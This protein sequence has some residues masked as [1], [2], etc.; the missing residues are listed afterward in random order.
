[1]NR[2]TILI[3]TFILMVAVLANASHL[4][5]ET[6]EVRLRSGRQITAKIHDRTDTDHLWLRYGTESVAV[7]RPVDWRTIEAAFH[8]GQPISVRQLKELASR[9]AAEV[10]KEPAVNSK[11]IIRVAPA[12]EGSQRETMAQRARQALGFAARVRSV[13]FEAVLSNWDGDVETD[14]L[15]LRLYPIDDRGHVIQVSGTLHV[16][17]I[18]RRQRDF[19]DARQQRGATV[20]QIGR[21]TVQVDEADFRNGVATV[22]LPFQ[23]IHPE[24]ETSWFADGIAHVRFVAAGNGTF[25]ESLDGIRV[26]PFSPLRD[27]MQ[28]QSG[29]RFLPSERTGRGQRSAG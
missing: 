25:E 3:R 26:R 21:W 7:I 11:R 6:V 17:L 9:A 8:E 16:E 20:D 10:A 22:R 13:Q 12:A 1:M 14:G 15:L 4:A 5:A 28:I 24:F 23:A 19:N 27:A 18:G 2:A 29:R